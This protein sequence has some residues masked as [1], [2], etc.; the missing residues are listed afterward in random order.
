VFDKENFIE[1]CKHFGMVN[2]KFNYL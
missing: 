1:F 2:I